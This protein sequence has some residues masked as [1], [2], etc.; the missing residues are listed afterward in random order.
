MADLLEPIA[1]TT[2]FAVPP[3]LQDR[4][5][6][7]TANGDIAETKRLKTLAVGTA[8]APEIQNSVSFMEKQVTPFIDI[9]QKADANG[10]VGTPTG[11]IAAADAMKEWAKTQPDTGLLK[12]IGAAFMGVPDSWKM[13][14]QGQIAPQIEYDKYGNGATV[15]YAQNNPKSPLY[16]IDPQTNQPIAPQDYQARGFGLFK[17]A[18]SSPF[19]QASGSVYKK[20]AEEFQKTAARTNLATAAYSDVAVNA[21][22][23]NDNLNYFANNFGFT[24]EQLNQLHSITSKVM[25]NEQSISNRIGIFIIATSQIGFKLS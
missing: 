6:A 25:T 23:I 12:G 9:K 22:K 2:N 4:F 14:T 24:N 7:A 18:S 20:N 5:N 8:L 17:D 15:F 13:M 3:A 19:I 16:V 10:G 21:S 1:P 11:N